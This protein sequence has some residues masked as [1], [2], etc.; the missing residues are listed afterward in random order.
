MLQKRD[1]RGIDD[2][3]RLLGSGV[4][5]PRH[6]HESGARQLLCHSAADTRRDP[7]VVGSPDHERRLDDSPQ[8]A[9][10]VVEAE[11]LKRPA[12]RAAVIGV[13]HRS[14]V[15]IEILSSD[16]SGVGVGGPQ[17]SSG[18]RP[19]AQRRRQGT[20]QRPTRHPE[21]ERPAGAESGSVD[22]HEPAHPV[23]RSQSDRDGD[24][25]SHGVSDEHRV[26]DVQRIE[27]REDESRVGGVAVAVRRLVREPEAAVVVGDR[28]ESGGGH[29]REGVSP[30]V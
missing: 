22:Q 6:Q 8:P 21:C 26:G 5:G 20:D 13:R 1:Q 10:K 24:R 27:Q 23:R 19:R 17:H 25:A 11:L 30:G 9:N 15:L 12:Q 28:S 18:R 7:A 3:W 14:V 16:S 29:R 4:A 2:L